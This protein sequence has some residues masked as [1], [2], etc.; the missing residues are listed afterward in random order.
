MTKKVIFAIIALV[1]FLGAALFW[2]QKREADTTGNA[3]TVSFDEQDIDEAVNRKAD[4]DSA[5]PVK[6]TD[7]TIKS[8]ADTP[9]PPGEIKY[10]F[11]K[12]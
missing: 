5:G 12:R 3:P 8:S 9:M 11:Y 1:L 7:E 6:W 4:Q 10:D 2:Y